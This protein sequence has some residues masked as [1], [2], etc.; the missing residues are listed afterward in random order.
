MAACED[1][2]KKQV[3]GDIQTEDQ[4]RLE[5]PFPFFLYLDPKEGAYSLQRGDFED[6]NAK[7][8]ISD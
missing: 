8:G 6:E 4:V 3:L 1:R 7:L 5:I 2:R